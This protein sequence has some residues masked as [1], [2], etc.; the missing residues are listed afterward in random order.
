MVALKQVWQEQRQQR[1]QE[2]VQRQQDVFAFLELSRQDL[3]AQTLQTRLSLDRFRE[4]L[5]QQEQLRQQQA[6]LDQYDRHQARQQRQQEIQAFL[7]ASREERQL[8]ALQ[9]AQRLDSYVLVLQQQVAQF[10][11]VNQAERS[12]MAQQLRQTLQAFHTVLS[13]E[14]IQKLAI[15]YQERQQVKAELHQSLTDFVELLRSDVKALLVDL[16]LDRQIL[17][18]ALQQT[19]ADSRRDRLA[20]VT[21][22]FQ[23]LGDFRTQLRQHRQ[24]VSLSV[25]GDATPAIAPPT[26]ARSVRVSPVAPKSR[27]TRASLKSPAN[28]KKV[29]AIPASTNGSKAAPVP[30]TPKPKTVDEIEKEVYNHIHQQQG[31]RLADLESALGINRFQ[32]VDALRSLIKKGLILQKD[33]VYQIQEEVHS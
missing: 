17:A 23:E 20:T 22:L 15:Y 28:G 25:W 33:R 16:E 14:V 2:V 6:T 3:A 29:T 30:P 31:I 26:T 13:A 4:Q 12:L 7:S 27:P 32:A 24:N 5:L 1:Q 10:L 19:L 21:A 18:E 9:L 11:S 8:A